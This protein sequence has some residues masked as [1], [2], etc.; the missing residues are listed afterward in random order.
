MAKCHRCEAPIVWTKTERGRWMPTEPRGF[1]VRKVDRD[2]VPVFDEEMHVAH[3][4][5]CPG[6]PTPQPK[7]TVAVGNRR[8]WVVIDG[9]ACSPLTGRRV[10]RGQA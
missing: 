9:E 6:R 1:E 10:E 2:G 8:S 5:F 7:V 3:F 4:Q